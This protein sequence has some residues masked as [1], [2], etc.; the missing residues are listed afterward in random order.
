MFR[1]SAPF[2]ELE[3]THAIRRS[4]PPRAH[5]RR[6]LLERADRRLPVEAIL[7]V[8]PF[9]VVATGKSQEARLHCRQQLHDVH[10]IAV[11]AVLVG[12]WK[13]RHEAE[14]DRAWLSRWRS[15][16]GL[17]I[18]R[19]QPAGLQRRGV[20]LPLRGDSRDVGSGPD[21]VSIVLSMDAVRG[22]LNL[23]LAFAQ[24]DTRVRRVRLDRDTPYPRSPRPPA[25]CLKS[26]PHRA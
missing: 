2:Q 20:L 16:N 3:Q 15:R 26:T 5:V 24:N 14:P 12:R 11:R 18:G 19:R 17:S 10:T 22:P 9:E 1:S 21:R 7:E 25:A 13:Q 23:P 4:V 8:G 6:P